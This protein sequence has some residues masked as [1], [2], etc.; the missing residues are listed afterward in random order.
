M[1]PVFMVLGKSSAAAA[2]L[3]LQNRHEI[4]GIPY[5][6]LKSR[7]IEAGQVLDFE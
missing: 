2:S 7:L 1:E 6:M 4:H 5:E 3:S